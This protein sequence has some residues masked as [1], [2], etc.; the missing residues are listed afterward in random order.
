MVAA[1]F[2]VVVA[3]NIAAFAIAHHFFACPA[4]VDAVVFGLIAA[5]SYCVILRYI[6][7]FCH[8]V[9]FRYLAAAFLFIVFGDFYASFFVVVARLVVAK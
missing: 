1:Y 3:G 9:V 4:F 6:T 5:A 8:F 7:A 2:F